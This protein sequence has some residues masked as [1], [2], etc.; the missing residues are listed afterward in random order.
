MRVLQS[1]RERKRRKRNGLPHAA[2]GMVVL[3]LLC[4]INSTPVTARVAVLYHNP[5]NRVEWNEYEPYS[6]KLPTWSYKYSIVLVPEVKEAILQKITA[7]TGDVPT[8]ES[9]G[10]QQNNSQSVKDESKPL[11]EN[12]EVAKS[13]VSQSENSPGTN[14]IHK[15]KEIKKPVN[16]NITKE[17][18]DSENAEKAA[19]SSLPD[20]AV[21]LTFD[22]GP[23]QATQGI[24]DL[25]NKYNAKA[26]FFMLEPNMVKY[27]DAIK[28]LKANGEGFGL[29]GVSH[30]ADIIYKSPQSVVGE[31]KKGETTL[32][33]MAGIDTHLIRTPYGS[34][35]YMKP[36][37]SKA[38][39]DAGF[40]L[41]D[42]NIDSED[43]EFPDGE[44]INNT[45]NQIKSFPYKQHKVILLHDK[46]S[47]L[48]HLEP[49]LVYLQKNNSEL[50]IIDETV[51][52]VQFTV[53]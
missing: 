33:S 34:A 40:I 4:G 24:I 43:W 1:I 41:W 20:H 53:K 7:K 3:A 47:T 22:D 49:L 26:T 25:L 27:P 19:P 30:R 36:D 8:N 48:E 2:A 23:S 45:I 31:M 15:E 16:N 17:K 12:N 38:V 50:K 14:P 51:K 39:K 28:E 29:H 18:P 5:F 13:I 46:P 10:K 6:A 44:F 11:R 21:Y 42:W 32:K 35:P 9:P 52:P 37:Y